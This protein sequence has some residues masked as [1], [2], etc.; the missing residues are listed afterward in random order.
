MVSV[1]VEG[2]DQGKKTEKR[3]ADQRIR[4]RRKKQITKKNIEDKNQ[5]R[6]EK[7][8]TRKKKRGKIKACKGAFFSFLI[9]PTNHI[10]TFNRLLSSFSHLHY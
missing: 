2:E 6:E 8:Q 3:N 5:I 1:D 10:Q 7:L 4:Q 9:M